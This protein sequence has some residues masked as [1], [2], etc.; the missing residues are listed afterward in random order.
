MPR[1]RRTDCGEELK[2]LRWTEQTLE[3][4]PKI[5]TK[6]VAVTARVRQETAMMAAWIAQRLRM[7]TKAHLTHLLY[8][9][10]RKGK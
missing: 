5:D 6:K 1:R 7:G 10:K 8:W 9:N 4:R 3:Q 2:R